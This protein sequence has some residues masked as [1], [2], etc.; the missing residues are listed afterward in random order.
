MALVRR[1]QLSRNVDQADNVVT[2]ILIDVNGNHAAKTLRGTKNVTCPGD[3][4]RHRRVWIGL[5]E[6][7]V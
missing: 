4:D 1:R 2:S 7:L 3:I 5:D 6:V